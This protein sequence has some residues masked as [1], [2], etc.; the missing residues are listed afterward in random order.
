MRGGLIAVVAALVWPAAAAAATSTVRVFDAAPAVSFRLQIDGKIRG[1][2]L[3]PGALSGPIALS[4]RRHLFRAIGAGGQ[5]LAAARLRPAAG[6]SSIVSLAQTAGGKGVLVLST[7]AVRRA[8]FASFRVI[9]LAGASGPIEFGTGAAPELRVISGLQFGHTSRTIFVPA[10]AAPDGV[11]PVHAWRSQDG[12]PLGRSELVVAIGGATTFAV[13]STATGTDL[14]RLPWDVAPPEPRAGPEITG[15]RRYANSVTCGGD[16]WTTTPAVTRVW[17]RDGIPVAGS[18]DLDLALTQG[19]DDGHTIGCQVTATTTG[20]SVTVLAPSFWLVHAPVPDGRPVITGAIAATST[21]TCG[22]GAWTSSPTALSYA[23]FRGAQQIESGPTHVLDRIL[24][25]ETPVTCTVTASNDGGEATQVALQPVVLGAPTAVT[26]P[27]IGGT[28]VVGGTLSR[29]GAGTWTYGV[30]PQLTYQWVRCA[31]SGMGCNPILGQTGATYHLT[32]TDIG[33]AVALQETASDPAD[34]TLAQSQWSLPTTAVPALL[35]LSPSDTV[36]QTTASLHGSVTA[37]GVATTVHFEYSCAS[38][39]TVSTPPQTLNGSDPITVDESVSGLTPNTAYTVSL[40]ETD[41][42][43]AR[44]AAG[45]GFT[46]LAN[47]PNTTVDAASAVA[48]TS[49]TLRGHVNTG[50]VAATAHFEY[51]ADPTFATFASTADVPVTTG[52][53]T[54]V[55]VPVTGL[56]ADTTYYVRLQ[57]TNNGGADTTPGTGSFTTLADV[58]VVT[59]GATSDITRTTA[60]LNGQ[61]NTNGVDA[62]AHFDYTADGSG[63]VSSTPDQNVPA[64][65]NQPVHAGIFG[66]APN[67]LYH[68]TLVVSNNGGTGQASGGDFTTDPLAPVPVLDATT[69]IAQTTATLNGHV[70]PS[71]VAATYHFEYSTD[72][73]T[74]PVF[75]TTEAS[76]PAG[77]VVSAT[78]G[79]LGL[80][81]NTTYQVRLVAT[82]AG[83]SATV[84][85]TF[86]TLPLPPTVGASPLND[87]TTSSVTLR[88]TVDPHGDPTA[89]FQFEW[90]TTLP[91]GVKL[92]GNATGGAVSAGLNTLA[93]STV[94]HYQLTAT[95]AGGTDTGADLAFRTAPDL[96]SPSTVTIIG[97]AAWAPGDLLTCDPGTWTGAPADNTVTYLWTRNGTQ[98]ASGA[99]YTVVEAD[100][101]ATVNCVVTVSNELAG[102]IPGGATTVNASNGTT[103]GVPPVNLTAPVA[104]AGATS[105]T[106]DPGTWRGGNITLTYAWTRCDDLTMTNNCGPAPGTTNPATGEYTYDVSDSTL[107]LQATVTA[108]N[109]LVPDGSATSNVIQAP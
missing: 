31:A 64:G 45:A 32:T 44:T 6:R 51:S 69:A 95:N 67:I 91:S 98:I 74:G 94:Y 55:L 104:T 30:T 11:L 96:V 49:A 46:T 57:A 21:L 18:A 109:G 15:T 70:D 50:G 42:A 68:V 2:T 90:G 3:A 101:G 5:I 75:P 28:P 33:H 26:P 71:G 54:A 61:V 84:S 20:G 23:W 60:T 43:S 1:S 38:C 105:A 83:G 10:T 27:T 16:T 77:G 53:A 24:D 88:G 87:I 19:V 97:P 37:G 8:G 76:V 17:T 93:P 78:I 63:V 65:S 85:D 72:F 4:P 34:A 36:A 99:T 100:F 35:T 13:V 86:T 92:G 52:A 58:P 62:T 66:L 39:A 108:T 81:P 56:S 89:T 14:V 47:P 103:V 40:V 80:D 41:P 106:V 29:T 9:D 22:D 25:F 79:P 7:T 48:M 102:G 107:F 73:L 82:N 59:V 12:S